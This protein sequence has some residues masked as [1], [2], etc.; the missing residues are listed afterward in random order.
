M[1]GQMR[2]EIL[3]TFALMG[4]ITYCLRSSFIVLGE[5][6]RLPEVVQRILRFAPAAALAALVIPDLLMEQGE[7]APLNPKLIAGVVVTLIV[8]RSRNPWLPFIFGM[9]VLLL[10][11]KGLGW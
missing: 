11:R 8:L 1:L 5:R 2:W 3:L 4:L 9:S 10:L 6:I 7:V